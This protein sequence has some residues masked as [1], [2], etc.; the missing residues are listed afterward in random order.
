MVYFV[1]DDECLKHLKIVVFTHLQYIYHKHLQVI[2]VGHNMV[3]SAIWKKTC[4]T[5]FF[6][7]YSVYEKLTSVFFQI[8]R[9]IMPL[10]INNRHDICQRE[11]KKSFIAEK[12]NSILCVCFRFAR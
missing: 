11:P 4:T 7:D 9:G 12:R 5:E 10:P 1:F 2:S 8:A 3:L 6:Q